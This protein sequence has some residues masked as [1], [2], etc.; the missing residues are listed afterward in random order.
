ML[1]YGEVTGL[2]HSPTRARAANASVFFSNDRSRWSGYIPD[3]RYQRLWESAE[4]GADPRA[5][6]EL[7]TTLG[8]RVRPRWV[9]RGR[10][11]PS[12]LPC[13]ERAMCPARER[14][15]KTFSQWRCRGTPGT[16]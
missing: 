3:Q 2:R 11:E 6:R 9:E 1:G 10:R 8:R 15:G 7:R 13:A 16:R 12:A 4:Q 14:L 5:L